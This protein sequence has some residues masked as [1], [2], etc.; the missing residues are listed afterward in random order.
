MWAT[1]S[2]WI[3]LKHNQ[4]IS[5]IFYFNLTSS[6]HRISHFRIAKCEIINNNHFIYRF[7]SRHEW[8]KK[9]NDNATCDPVYSVSTEKNHKCDEFSN[10]ISPSVCLVYC[11]ATNAKIAANTKGIR[12]QNSSHNWSDSFKSIL[13]NFGFDCVGYLIKSFTGVRSNGLTQ[14]RAEVWIW[15]LFFSIGYF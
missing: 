10:F 8:Q 4:L 12:Y 11:E 5:T 7:T 2:K 3:K 15:Q 9:L 1:L 6:L 13:I 14:G